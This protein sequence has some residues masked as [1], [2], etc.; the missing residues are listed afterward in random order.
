[1]VLRCKADGNPD[2]QYE[3]YRN[4]LRIFRNDRITI[5]GGRKLQILDISAVD[6]GIYSCKVQS[7]AGEMDSKVNFPLTLSHPN[8]AHIRNLPRDLTVRRSESAYFDCI[9]DNAAITDWYARDEV[10]LSNS[11]RIT[12]YPNG[13]LYIHR[14][15]ASDEGPYK[16]VGTKGVTKDEPVQA[17]VVELRIA[18]LDT[19]DNNSFEP[20]WKANAVN[21]VAEGTEFE[22]TCLRPKG[23][24]KPTVWWEYGRGS[25]IS[26]TGRIH[27]D[28]TRLVIDRV[29]LADA[30]NYTCIAENMAGTRKQY[31][32]VYVT[33]PPAIVAG[34]VGQLI[35]EGS[36]VQFTCAY[37]GS[38]FPYTTIYWLKD[39]R[40]V[41]NDSYRVFIHSHNGSL[42]IYNV[43]PLDPGEYSCEIHTSGFSSIQSSPAELRVNENLKFVPVPVNRKLELSSKSKIYCKAR[44]SVKPVVRWVKEGLPLLEWPSHIKD[45][46]GTLY[47][48][49]VKSEDAGKYTCV[50][51]SSQG[52]INSTIQVD[53]IVTP[54]FTVKP[55]NT[56]AYEGY[57]V[58]LHCKAYGD[59]QP[60]I[61]WD[62]NSILNGFDAKRFHVMDNG[63]LH[64]A[65]V[66]MDD[67]GK[68]GCT[69]GNSGGFKREEISLFVKSSEEFRPTLDA[70]D[71]LE[72]K[73]EEN[74]MTKTVTITLG[75]A[76]AYMI[77]VIGLMVWCKY[78]RARKKALYLQ[79]ANAEGILLNKTENG[80]AVHEGG[81]LQTRENTARNEN[82]EAGGSSH[83][84]HS[85]RSRQSYDKL[86]FPRHDLQTIMLLGKGEFGDVILAKAKGIMDGE[87]ETIVMV[88]TLQT[89][90]EQA[91]FNYRRE[92]D[93]YNKLNHDNIAKLLGVCCEAEP[94]FMIM[95]Y[96][97]WGDL[98]QFLLATRKDNPRKSPRPP[99]LILSQIVA[100]CS[101]IS[102]GMEYL[103]NHRLIHKD[104]AARNCLVTSNL[105]IKISNPSLSK[106]TYSRE[107]SRYHGHQLPVRWMAPEA[108]TDGDFSTKS[109]VYSYAVIVWEIFSQADLPFANLSDES[110]LKMAKAKELQWTI[111]SSCPEPIQEMLQQCW[112]TSPKERPLFGEIVLCIADVH[113]D[114]NV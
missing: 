20:S 39:G 48:D 90:D 23:Y 29:K 9:Y 94:F 46:N 47:F 69:A 76:V 5:H 51:T 86:Q 95:E 34:P 102:L 70:I 49:S 81:E 14:V 110:Y 13:T 84:L 32:Q 64:V 108:I 30:G 91:H 82:G 52:I 25:V 109:D 28:D 93:M 88:K 114:S 68:Y 44:G 45:E 3:W 18:E 83:S 21:I 105:D 85:K 40:P 56:E 74:M 38:P 80:D 1:M 71:T 12:I 57:P 78:K 15:K 96:S 50:A 61:Q 107:Y 77:L 37:T 8:A 35:D 6:N 10:L 7:D 65:E 27:V 62:K 19:M 4:N 63:S 100:M 2:L 53:I 24:P 55:S 41:R 73:K 92:L 104:L 106:D 59:P 111:P 99:Q 60:T 98:K 113:V 103:S 22:I 79:Q 31:I 36:W 66:H 33:V 67:Q 101:Q 87:N 89:R 97:D 72:E 112:S 43:N 11:T 16:C 75:S 54:K 42:V 17:Y 26:D 58:V